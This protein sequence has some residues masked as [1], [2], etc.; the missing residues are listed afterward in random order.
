MLNKNEAIENLN[1]VRAAFGAL[2]VDSCAVN[3]SSVEWLA[4]VWCSESIDCW[5]IGKR[6]SQYRQKLEQTLSWIKPLED[7][8][9][10]EGERNEPKN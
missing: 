6:I 3:T 1:A 9:L 8:F 10:K 7:M 2:T 5:E 4:K